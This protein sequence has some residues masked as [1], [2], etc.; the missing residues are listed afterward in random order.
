MIIKYVL[1][2]D[3]TIPDF[4]DNGG[5]FMDPDDMA[6]TRVGK[7][8][9]SGIP[10]NTASTT[11]EITKA[12]LITRQADIMERYPAQE[13]PITK[14]IDSRTATEI[15]TAWCNHVGE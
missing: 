10:S 9:A 15:I 8:I 14:E 2:S 7:V 6:K 1:N 11:V 3:G 4:V 5:Y 13:D 12:E